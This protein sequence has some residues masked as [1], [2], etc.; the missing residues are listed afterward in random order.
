MTTLYIDMA[1]KSEIKILL[2]ADKYCFRNTPALL[3]VQNMG[4]GLF[5]NTANTSKGFILYKTIHP[6]LCL[7]DL[8]LN[9]KTC[10]A[11]CEK[12]RSQ[13]PL[14]PI[15]LFTSHYSETTYLLCRHLC[16]F[17]ILER[18]SSIT[19][20]Y[21][22]MDLALLH[23]EYVASA[24]SNAQPPFKFATELPYFFK[25]GEMYKPMQPENIAFFHTKDHYT[26]A[27][28]DN[29]DEPIQVSLKIL[30]QYLPNTFIRIHKKYLINTTHIVSIHPTK[31]SIIIG[32]QTLPI[33][34]VFRKSFLKDIPLL[35]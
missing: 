15:I 11:L 1:I 21:Q 28:I 33:G 18:S 32:Y 9:H 5:F 22:T 17:S 25:I 19:S 13:D 34:D 4:L 20:F 31:N 7:I 26:F 10:I 2:V 14:L 23:Y 3:G 6:S 29:Y 35:R 27:R 30:E 24:Q 8:D 16:P 12:I